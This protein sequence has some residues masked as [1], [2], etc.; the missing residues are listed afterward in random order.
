MTEVLQF[1]NL[2]H[3]FISLVGAVLLLAIYYNIRSRFRKILE[4]DGKQKRVDKGLLY[5]SLAMF[6]WVASGI[7]AFMAF[8]YDFLDSFIYQVGVNLLS[9]CNNLFLLLAIFYFNHAPHFIYNHE[10]NVKFILWL[11]VGVTFATLTLTFYFSE[12]YYQGIHI[13]ALPDLLL[14]GFLSLLLGISMYKTF[15]ARGLKWV[16]ILS[17]VVIILIFYSQLPEV[18]MGLQDDFQNLLIKIIAKTSLIAL[19]LVLATTWV[20]QLSNTPRINEISIDFQDWS[21]IK[22]NIPSKQI[23]NASID[24]GSKT[25]QFKNLFKFALRRKF[26]SGSDQS[27]EVS[28]LGEIKNQTYLSRILDN[29]NEILQ[30]EGERQLVRSDLFTFL[31]EGKY[32]LRILPEHIEVRDDLK[33]EFIQHAENQAYKTLC[34]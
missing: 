8:N 7:W 27:L 2:S 30:L 28:A 3:T 12:N 24:F 19:F 1:H 17:L 23:S 18:F 4:E 33:N 15:S 26:A 29:I 34:D 20:I 11:I 21:L 32:R 5:L 14:S 25:T 16:A 10:K 9:I 6:V 22:L 13:N 31:G